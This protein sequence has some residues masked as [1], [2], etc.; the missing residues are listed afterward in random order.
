VRQGYSASGAPALPARPGAAARQW[1][2][3]RV[4]IGV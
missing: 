1:T 3:T 4:P 2:S